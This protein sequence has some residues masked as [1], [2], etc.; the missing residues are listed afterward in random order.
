MIDPTLI[1]TVRT[2]RETVLQI[3]ALSVRVLTETGNVGLRPRMEA[4]VLAVEASVV[5][6]LTTDGMRFV[7]TAGGLMWCDGV[8][9][10]L[11]SPL[12]VFGDNADDIADKLERVMSQP[13]AEMQARVMLSNL[14]GKIINELRHE[15]KVPVAHP[16]GDR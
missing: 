14:E 3:A 4:T 6:V 2:P 13:S 1:F 9:A 8:E 12:A 7:G 15:Q 11:L 5:N 16:G 10:T